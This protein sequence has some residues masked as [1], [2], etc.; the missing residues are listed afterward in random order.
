MK[1]SCFVMPA[2]NAAAESRLTTGPSCVPAGGAGG[3]HD[4]VGAAGRAG[5]ARGAVAVVA[6]VARAHDG[7]GRAAGAEPRTRRQ[8]R[9]N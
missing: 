4:G 5:T 1:D 6:R 9:I 2:R 3:G 7:V 8:K